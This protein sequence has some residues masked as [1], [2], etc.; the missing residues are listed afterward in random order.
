M[1]PSSGWLL[2]N[3]NYSFE[4]NIPVKNPGNKNNN[5]YK[6]VFIYCQVKNIRHFGVTASKSQTFK[7]IN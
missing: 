7:K 5:I 6:N 1:V 2:W 4:L 3:W